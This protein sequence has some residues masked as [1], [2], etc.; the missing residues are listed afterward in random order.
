[1]VRIYKAGPADGYE[2]VH[3]HDHSDR[4]N[5]LELDQKPVADQFQPLP[6]YRILEDEGEVFKEADMP[7]MGGH[8]LVLRD[9]VRETLE[10]VMS[11]DVEFLPLITDD[12]LR[13]WITHALQMVP[14]LDL[15][16]SEVNRFPSS[17]RI[18]RI[19]RHHFL[20]TVEQAGVAFHL[21]EMKRGHLYV[22]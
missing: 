18:M 3:L 8:F 2:W 11:K 10:P 7:W 17:G 21:E 20:P 22:T 13:L 4:E 5:L 19:V 15:Q 9:H 14:G 16:H 1:M 6:A 12:D